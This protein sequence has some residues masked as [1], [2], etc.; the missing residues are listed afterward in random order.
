MAVLK[1]AEESGIPLKSGLMVGLGETAEEVEDV[2]VNLRRAEVKMVTIGQYLSPS[3]RHLPIR[4][5][6][7]PEIFEA[8]GL[9]ARDLGFSAVIS[10]PFVRSSYRAEEIWAAQ[11]RKKTDDNKRGRPGYNSAL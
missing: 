8:Y 4:E 5:F 1:K 10:A 6:V 11:I 9:I 3:P 2:L 7:H